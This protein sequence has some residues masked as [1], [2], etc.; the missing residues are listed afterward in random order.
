MAATDQTPAS[1][2][3]GP[4]AGA[5]VVGT[6][7]GLGLF[8]LLAWSAL[9]GEPNPAAPGPWAVRSPDTITD[10]RARTCH[11]CGKAILPGQPMVGTLGGS[12]W[13]D[14]HLR[15]GES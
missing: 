10:P 4:S 14:F 11:A 12:G 8:G 1:T 6:V 13:L 15:H 2:T 5:I 9:R 3:K 7:I